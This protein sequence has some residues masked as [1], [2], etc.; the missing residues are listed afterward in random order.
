MTGRQATY[1]VNACVVARAPQ[2]L[3]VSNCLYEV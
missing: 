3:G 1:C 2:L